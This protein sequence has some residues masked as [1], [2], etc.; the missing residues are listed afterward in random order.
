MNLLFIG[1]GSWGTAALNGCLESMHRVFVVDSPLVN[2]TKDFRFG[3]F[4]REILHRNRFAQQI[5]SFLTNRSN[6]FYETTWKFK[7]PVIVSISVNSPQFIN[8][9]KSLGIDLILVASC[10]EIL[11]DDLIKSVKLGCVNCHPSLLPKYR[12][13]NPFFWVLRNNEKETGVSFHLVNKT[14]DGGKL[15]LQQKI[16]ILDSDNEE[17]LV[18]KCAKLA[19]D[20]MPELLIRFENNSIFSENQDENNASYYSNLKD[21]PLC[22]QYEITEF[23]TENIN[24]WNEMI[25]NSPQYNFFSTSF[26]LETV[27]KLTGDSFKVIACKYKGILLCGCAAFLRK[28]L[29]G[30]LFTGAPLSQYSSILFFPLTKQEVIDRV[31]DVYFNAVLRLTEYVKTNFGWSVLYLHPNFKEST[32]LRESHWLVNNRYTYYL[33]L[34]K[35]DSLFDG[36]DNMLKRN[37]RKCRKQDFEFMDKFNTFSEFYTLW[38]HNFLRQKIRPS[39]NNREFEYI[40]NDLRKNN[41]CKTICAYDKGRNLAS[42]VIFLVDKRVA[43]YWASAFNRVFSNT[44]INQFLIWEGLK[45]LSK[46]GVENFDFMGADVPSIAEF[47]KRFGGTLVPHYKASI[48]CSDRAKVIRTGKKMYNLLL[49]RDRFN[50]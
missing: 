11:K 40:Y 32:F 34:T 35:G 48:I 13:S 39:L 44:G 5:Y 49:N 21:D 22:T 7:A 45:Q 31:E 3:L 9:I 47:K 10:T 14:I 15:L 23:S 46:E 28:S 27:S 1:G 42:A 12:G 41:F 36:F 24:L 50:G 2:G 37:I 38:N 26:W 30:H 25:E 8:K 16:P 33:D 18:S 43:Y 6:I 20:M 4:L 29:E 17:S 19:L